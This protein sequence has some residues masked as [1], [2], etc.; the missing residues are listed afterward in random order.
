[1]H[2]LVIGKVDG[3]YKT[4]LEMLASTELLIIDVPT[5]ADAISDRLVH[6]AYQITLKG[7]YMRK[8]MANMS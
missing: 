8:L 3:S 1:L 5:L 2:D 4:Q 6:N 7:E